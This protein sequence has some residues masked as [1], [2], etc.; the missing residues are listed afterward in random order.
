MCQLWWY[1]NANLT[2][3]CASENK[4]EACQEGKEDNHAG[5]LSMLNSYITH[6]FVVI[7]IIFNHDKK[8][9]A[10]NSFIR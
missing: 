6:H 5:M 4:R 3:V 2:V 10:C 1:S 9:G 7:T 8:L